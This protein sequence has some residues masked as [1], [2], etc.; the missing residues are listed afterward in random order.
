MKKLLFFLAIALSITGSAM[1][2]AINTRIVKDSIFIP[3]EII[4]GPDNNIWLTQKNGYICRLHPATGILDT[5]YHETATVIQNEGGMLG[6]A[7]HPQFA[8]QPYVFVVYDYLQGSAY[9]ERVVRYTYNG[10]N[11]LTTPTILLDNVIAGTNHNGSRLLI[12]GDKLFITTG[13]VLVGSNAQNLSSPNGKIHRINLDGSI[14]SDNPIG[15]STL[16]SWGHRN[17]QGLVY[18]NGFLYSSEHGPSNDDELNIIKKGRNYGWPT[19]M[20]FCDQ[21]SEMQFCTDSNVVQPLYAWTPPL[22]VCGT[23]YYGGATLPYTAFTWLTGSLIMCT[24]ANQH[25]YQLKLNAAKDSIVSVSIINGVAFGRLRDICISPQGKIYISTS[26]S[27]A[28]GSGAKIDRIVELSDPAATNSIGNLLAQGIRIYP[29]PAG[30]YLQVD[31]L[32]N[33]AA[34]TISTVAGQKITDGIVAAGA[35]VIDINRL[36][37]G[38]YLLRIKDLGTQL[39][40]KE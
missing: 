19:V 34:Y 14:P 37:A 21:P 32:K 12:V 20:G 26:N 27:S 17:P 18:A 38:T 6:M 5:L 29:N 40:M 39:F 8:T 2:Q 35:T 3:W 16:W 9:R 23:D 22:A 11:A 13:D 31:G 36:A 28:S 25:L 10:S 30:R 7:L 4:W 1:A 33:G 15:G 24:L